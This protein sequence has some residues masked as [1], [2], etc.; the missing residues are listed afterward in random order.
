MTRYIYSVD[1]HILFIGTFAGVT[2]LASEGCNQD[3]KGEFPY[4][5]HILY[6]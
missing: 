2:D 3:L 5:I 4:Y 6:L 1:I